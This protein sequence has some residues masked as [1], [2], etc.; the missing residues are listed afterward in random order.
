MAQLS[1]AEAAEAAPDFSNLP[2]I[3]KAGK[4]GVSQQT[5]RLT[6]QTRNRQFSG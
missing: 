4:F 2:D 1:K 3:R 5:L 6:D